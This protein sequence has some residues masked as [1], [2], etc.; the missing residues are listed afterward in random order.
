MAQRCYRIKADGKSRCKQT[1]DKN[2]R[3][4]WHGAAT[5]PAQATVAS[6][7]P[8]PTS[9]NAPP[10]TSPSGS[11]EQHPMTQWQQ[12]P[13]SYWKHAAA[14]WQQRSAQIARELDTTRTLPTVEKVCLRLR[15]ELAT[16][17]A[18]LCEAGGRA[19]FPNLYSKDSGLLNAAL[20]EDHNGNPVWEIYA[21]DDARQLANPIKRIPDTPESLAD[22]DIERRVEHVPAWARIAVPNNEIDNLPAALKGTTVEIFR[23]DFGRPLDIA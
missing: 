10:F 21:L 15:H 17:R 6:A 5:T 1:L 9:V 23:A 3:C 2:G 20:R 22:A 13:P 11:S 16:T 12:R 19:P 8:A 4:R 18:A 14:K 7:R